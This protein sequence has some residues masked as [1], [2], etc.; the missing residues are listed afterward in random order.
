MKIKL[1]NFNLNRNDT[2]SRDLLRDVLRDVLREERLLL[3]SLFLF[4]Y[5]KMQLF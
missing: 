2:F 4:F 5:E 3:D 1:K